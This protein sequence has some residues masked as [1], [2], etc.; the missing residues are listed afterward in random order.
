MMPCCPDF[1][2]ASRSTRRDLLRAGMIG[3]M[4]GL[5]LPALLRARTE[6]GRDSSP[7]SSHEPSTSCSCINGAGRV[8]STPSI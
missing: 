4:A 3:G 2:R 1:D 7:G 8:T 6:R 5:S